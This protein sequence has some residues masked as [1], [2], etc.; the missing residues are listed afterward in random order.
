[1]CSLIFWFWSSLPLFP[2]SSLE[3]FSHCSVSVCFFH[4]VLQSWSALLLPRVFPLMLTGI[5]YKLLAGHSGAPYIPSIEKVVAGDLE[6]KA[7][8]GYIASFR[9]PWPM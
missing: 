2:L 1:M 3:A 9:P 7:S 6:Y 5:N 4:L 8:V